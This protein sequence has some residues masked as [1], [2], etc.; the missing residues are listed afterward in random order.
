[1]N[2][3]KILLVV[4]V[5]FLGS[6]QV[7]SALRRGFEGLTTIDRVRV[8]VQPTP[9]PVA[10]PIVI[11]PRSARAAQAARAKATGINNAAASNVELTSYTHPVYGLKMSAGNTLGA[12]ST[13]NEK[14]DAHI[15]SAGKKYN[16]DPLLIYSLMHQESTFKPKAVSN[17]G[18]RGL[19]QLMPGTA[20][21]FG[22]S[23]IFDP[24]QNIHG[25][26][27]YLR[28]L[29]DMFDGDVALA[30]AGY[31]AGEGAVLK[32]GRKVPPFMETQEYVRRITSRYRLI[33]DPNAMRVVLPTVTAKNNNII[34]SAPLTVYERGVHVAR[35]P[36]GKT[37]LVN[38]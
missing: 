18:A 37:Q 20:A 3:L 2:K 5:S 15:V 23:N 36:N 32:Y 6:L 24:E 17:K 34:E 16:V 4:S 33:R 11:T 30:L 29:L 19:M 9:T 21:R 12:Y 14:I 38:W 26:T 31:N 1:M 8:P 7:V 27:R 10:K 25:G 22:V 35:L 13:G 28:L